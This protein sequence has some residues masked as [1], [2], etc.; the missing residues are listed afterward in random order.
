MYG[1]TGSFVA[2][3]LDPY[4]PELYTSPVAEESDVARLACESWVPLQDLGFLHNVEVRVH[5]DHSVHDD[6]DVSIVGRNLLGVPLSGG[7]QEPRPRRD[8]IVDRPVVLGGLEPTFIARVSVVE[9]LNLHAD[10]R[11]VALK[12]RSDAHAAVA[13]RLH[14]EI[15]SEDEIRELL[16]REE[17]PS[18]IRRADQH[19]I[20]G[21]VAGSVTIDEGPTVEGLA[22]E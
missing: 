13:A 2:Q 9:D 16:F 7:P 3:F 18:A 21:D 15:E 6:P 12:R 17:V 19:A 5:N 14:A 20:F 4:V 1:P 22:V 8:H 10:V 11:S